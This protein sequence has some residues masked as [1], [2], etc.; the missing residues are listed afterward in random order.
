[1][2]EDSNLP[3]DRQEVAKI[4]RRGQKRRK[5]SRR[6]K[7]KKNNA[8]GSQVAA[9]KPLEHEFSARRSKTSRRERRSGERKGQK[10]AARESVELRAGP[11]GERMG[12]VKGRGD[13]SWSRGSFAPLVSDCLNRPLCARIRA[14]ASLSPWPRLFFSRSLKRDDG[15]KYQ[16]V[17]QREL[18]P[19]RRER[20]GET[21]YLILLSTLPLRLLDVSCFG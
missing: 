1:M 11:V 18:H 15:S 6:R 9:T 4:R 14:F 19:K 20:P 13:S 7:R 8:T 16:A 5:W 10:E 17:R 12:K 21:T 2:K 3:R